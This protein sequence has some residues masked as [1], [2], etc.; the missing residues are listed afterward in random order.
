MLAKYVSITQKLLDA[1]SSSIIMQGIHKRTYISTSPLNFF[2][3]T[4]HIQN[5]C[6]QSDANSITS[7]NFNPGNKAYCGMEML[8]LFV[9]HFPNSYKPCKHKKNFSTCSFSSPRQP[10]SIRSRSLNVHT[11]CKTFMYK[12]MVGKWQFLLPIQ[13][14]S[15][16]SKCLVILSKKPSVST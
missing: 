9:R 1:F 3:L 2:P 10:H 7:L 13:R 6:A 11:I 15:L 5:F 16:P 4:N 8:I 14:V 12:V